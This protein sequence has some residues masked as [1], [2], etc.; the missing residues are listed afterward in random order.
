MLLGWLVVGGFCVVFVCCGGFFLFV[1]V[2]VGFFVVWGF[3]LSGF[4]LGFYDSFLFC[5]VF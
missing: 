2:V 3:F 1:W 5:F 4:C